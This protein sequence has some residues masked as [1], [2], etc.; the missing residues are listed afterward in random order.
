MH[1]RKFLFFTSNL[2]EAFVKT[3]ILSVRRMAQ[4]STT[5]TSTETSTAAGGKEHVKRHYNHFL[6]PNNV[7][8]DDEMKNSMISTHRHGLLMLNSDTMDTAWVKRIWHQCEFKICADGGANRL[9]D[10]L[11]ASGDADKYIP[12]MIKGDL[13]SLRAD[14][15]AFYSAAGTRIVYDLDQVTNDTT[16]DLNTLAHLHTCVSQFFF[17]LCFFSS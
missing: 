17:T 1:C 11:V 16:D 5:G 9:Y 2:S 10:G 8:G 12:D 4:F 6:L 13:D 14:V 7:A 15:K 3:R